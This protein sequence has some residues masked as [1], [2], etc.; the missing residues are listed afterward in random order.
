MNDSSVGL[1]R[2]TYFCARVVVWCLF[3]AR[4]GLKACVS[5]SCA[6]LTWHFIDSVAKRI[7]RLSD[8]RGHTEA[9]TE[10][11]SSVAKERLRYICWSGVGVGGGVFGE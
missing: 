8:C 11:L 6:L 5:I 3:I 10:E 1:Y 7:G 9:A 2:V 4:F